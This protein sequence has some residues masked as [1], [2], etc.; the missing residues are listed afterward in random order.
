MA[1]MHSMR[2]LAERGLGIVGDAPLAR[3]RL[4]EMRDIYGFFERSLP[5]LFDRWE[6][7]RGGM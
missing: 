5:T 2:A 3:E 4:E 6:R 7:E 1:I